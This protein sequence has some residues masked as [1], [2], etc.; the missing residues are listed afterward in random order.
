[1]IS[2][3]NAS[4]V[5]LAGSSRFMRRAQ[6]LP[7]LTRPVRETSRA[8]RPVMRKPDSTKNTSTPTNPPAMNGTPACPISTDPTAIVRMP[9][10]SR[11]IVRP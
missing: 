5:A 2:A 1:V 9:S 4:T 6:K 11:R 3:E 10:M 7:R 8:S